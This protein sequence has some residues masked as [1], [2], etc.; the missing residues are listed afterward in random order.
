MAVEA[1]GGARGVAAGNVVDQARQAK[2]T[3]YLVGTPVGNLEDIS[4]RVARILAEADVI[5]AED[6]RHTRGLLTHL[7]LK[8]PLISYNQ[9]SDEARTAEICRRVA[10][11][12]QVA[13]VT[14]AGMPGISDPGWRLAAAASAQN[15]PVVP[16]PGPSALTLALAGSGLPTASFVFDGFL[17]RRP[18]QRRRRLAELGALGVTIVFYESPH[19]VIDAL[20]DVGAAFGDTVP[21]AVGRELTKLHEEF[22]RGQAREVA[23]LLE[24]RRSGEKRLRGE[25][26]VVV[27]WG[28]RKR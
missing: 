16:V 18:G 9:H 14:D 22:L 20:R 23:D 3:L 21:V 12:E 15:L 27:G 10:Q 24:L 25:F 7:G 4:A 11:G 2:G 17:P 28:E 8:T 5:A 19:R 1:A 13:V 26:T 6:P